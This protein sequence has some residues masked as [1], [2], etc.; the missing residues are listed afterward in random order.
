[1]IVSVLKEIF[2]FMTPHEPI[3]TISVCLFFLI[4][5]SP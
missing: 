2:D 4:S 1:M 3:L 5:N